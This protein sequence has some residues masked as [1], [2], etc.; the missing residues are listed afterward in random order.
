MCPEV[1]K[2][3][4]GPTIRRGAKVGAN[5]CVLPTVIVGEYAV[6]AAG[7]VVVNDVPARMVAAGNPAKIIKTVD[8]L[9]CPWDYISHPYPGR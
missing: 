5:A 6:I 4:K 2:C 9:T 8:D 3:I 1:A 7:S